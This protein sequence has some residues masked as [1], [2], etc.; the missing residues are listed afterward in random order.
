MTEHETRYTCTTLVIFADNIQ[1]YFMRVY[2]GTEMLV[3]AKI[4]E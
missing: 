1:H 3:R 4:T 2:T